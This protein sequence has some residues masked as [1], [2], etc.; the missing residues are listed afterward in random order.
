MRFV[1]MKTLEPQDIWSIHR[2]RSLRVKQRTAVANPIRG[3]M[4]EYA[5]VV[6]RGLGQ[7]RKQL[8]ECL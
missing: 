7:L 5:V 2:A 4:A 3:L 8:P 1:P 6:A